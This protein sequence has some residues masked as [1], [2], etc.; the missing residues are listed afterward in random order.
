MAEPLS[1]NP[2]DI[3]DDCVRFSSPAPDMAPFVLENGV[4]T[5]PEPEAPNLR[6]WTL[7]MKNIGVPLIVNPLARLASQLEESIDPYATARSL[8]LPVPEAR[9]FNPLAAFM[10]NP[11]AGLSTLSAKGI[12]NYYV[13]LRSDTEPKH[14]NE[15]PL[16][17]DQVV[18]FITE[19]VKPDSYNAYLLR[20]AEY[21]VAVCGMIIVINPSGGKHI[22]MV[23]GDLGPLATGR[24]R[25][26]YQARTDPFTGVLRYTEVNPDEDSQPQQ[27]RSRQ[28]PDDHP[29]VSGVLRTAIRRTIKCIPRGSSG[30][31]DSRMPGRY[32]AALVNHAGNIVPVFVDAQP[33]RGNRHPYALPEESLY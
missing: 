26:E 7:G 32:E 13:G 29:I 16:S 25:P 3:K 31:R 14:R 2:T 33:D 20:V 21:V 23:M 22:D 27:D 10:A 4:E 18:P 15:A 30:V 28:L 24:I 8:G 9:S 1:I 5:V 11:E 19:R 6:A 17:I 12:I